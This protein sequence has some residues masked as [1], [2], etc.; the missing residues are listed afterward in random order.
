M[1][2]ST[3]LEAKA[4]ETIDRLMRQWTYIDPEYFSEDDRSS[5]ASTEPSFP[6]CW[7]KSPQNTHREKDIEPAERLDIPYNV[8]RRRR[9][10][11][12]GN[13]GLRKEGDGNQ[14]VS[15][16][17]IF[18]A[19]SSLPAVRSHHNEK[20]RPSPLLRT[21]HIEE[22]GRGAEA[23]TPS[24]NPKNQVSQTAREP[25]TPALPY[26]S[27]QSGYCPS[28]HAGAPSAPT[29][30]AGR[31]PGQPIDTDTETGKVT[32]PLID[33]DHRLLEN[34]ALRCW[35]NSI[36]SSRIRQPSS[37]TTITSQSSSSKRLTP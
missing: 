11:I 9:S 3:L 20:K 18:N 26:P 13:R 35:N 8:S 15:L 31:P 30:C 14:S 22:G 32:S 21:Y 4:E 7:D 6:V 34:K 1:S 29:S 24:P 5:I 12:M 2:R 19:P 17:E 37:K 23:K 27:S 16:E 10:D 25:S 28:C 33:S 36:R